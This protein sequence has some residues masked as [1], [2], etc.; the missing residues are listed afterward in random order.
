MTFVKIR[1]I[2]LTWFSF[3]ITVFSY[4]SLQPLE[5]NYIFSFV[6]NTLF[7]DILV[8]KIGRHLIFGII[9]CVRVTSSYGSIAYVLN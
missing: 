1:G 6:I 7:P 8:E 5:L 4:F 3:I 9:R 2:D